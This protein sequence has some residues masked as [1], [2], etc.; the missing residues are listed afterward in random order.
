MSKLV[1]NYIFNTMYQ[2]LILIL[3]FLS[4][5]YVARVLSPQGIGISSYTTSVVQVFMFFAILGIQVYGNRQ[6][7]LVKHKGKKELS[8]QFCS[9]YSIQFF[10]SIIMIIVYMLFVNYYVET[11]KHIFLIQTLAIIGVLLDISWLF[12]GLEELKKVVTR[13]ALI[14]L[15][16]VLLIFILVKEPKDLY[17]YVLIN[18]VSN[19]IGQLIMWLQ[20][21]KYIVLTPIKISYVMEHIKPMIMIF[22]P[23]I[24]IQL[25]TVY[26]KVVLGVTAGNVDV[27]FYDQAL[28]VVQLTLAIVTSLGTVMLPRI[29]SEYAKGNYDNINRYINRILRFVLFITMPM[30]IGLISISAQFIPWFLGTGYSEVV[31]LI[32]IISPIIIFIGC[33]NVFGM[34]ILI[35]TQQQRKYTIAVASGAIMSVITNICLVNSLGSIGTAIALLMAEGIGVL[36]QGIF[37]RSFIEFKSV[38]RY[39]YKYLLASVFMGGVVLSIGKLVNSS[40]VLVILVQISTAIIVYVILMIVIKDELFILILKK[41]YQLFKLNKINLTKR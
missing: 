31:V 2:F 34:Q 16:S 13:N 28:K 35:P 4:T 26:N 15:T 27:G 9:I 5:P 39:A 1:S 6:V 30:C 37:V 38:L 19:I 22:L 25:Y 41:I 40:G 20:I 12:I 3:P 33:A 36:I 8:K 17:L 23:L 11:N 18:V 21:S 24:F 10:S 7:A 32:R 14:K 29:S